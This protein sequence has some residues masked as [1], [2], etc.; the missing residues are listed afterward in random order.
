MSVDGKSG[1]AHLFVH[2]DRPRDNGTSGP[3]FW[4]YGVNGSGATEIWFGPF[5]PMR[6]T[7]Q[8][9]ASRYWDGKV[10]EKTG[11]GYARA[12]EVATEDV[13]S[14]LDAGKACL[15][16]QSLAI[17]PKLAEPVRKLLEEAGL[18]TAQRRDW[19]RRMAELGALRPTHRPGA[20]GPAIVVSVAIAD[21]SCTDDLE[22][23][24]F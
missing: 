9:K 5:V 14:V 12:C 23:Q 4:I 2:R 17:K 22:V 13:P 24:V 1:R 8:V 15:G 7:H 11:K 6:W 10:E 16:G 18:L 19:V 3:A 21:T 20:S